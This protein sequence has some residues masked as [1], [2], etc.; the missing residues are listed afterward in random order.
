MFC[1]SVFIQIFLGS[2]MFIMFMVTGTVILIN[3]FVMIVMYEFEEVNCSQDLSVLL[4][5]CF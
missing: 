2:V 4:F 5:Y 1:Y 3:M